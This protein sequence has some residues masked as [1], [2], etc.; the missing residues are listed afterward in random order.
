MM[1][2]KE[3]FYFRSYPNFC[4]FRF[5]TVLWKAAPK[6]HFGHLN[7]IIYIYQL[8]ILAY[9]GVNNNHKAIYFVYLATKNT[10][11]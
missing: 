10:H 11:I 1:L 9:K 4:H 8:V 3:E 5:V 6:A 2:K 7:L